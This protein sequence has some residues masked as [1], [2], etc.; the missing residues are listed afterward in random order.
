MAQIVGALQGAGLAAA[1]RAAALWA[2]WLAAERGRFALWLPVFMGA[3]DLAYFSLRGE[4]PGWAGAALLAPSLAAALLARPWPL[5]RAGLAAAAAA[6]FGFAAAQLAAARAPPLLTLPNRATVL[7]GTVDAMEILPEGRRITLRHATLATEA[8]PLPRTLR[9]RLRNDDAAPVET[10]DAV[11]LRAMV[12][13]PSSP[14]Y[15]GAWDVQRDDFFNGIGGYGFALGGVETLTHAPPGGLAQRLHALRAGIAARIAAALPGATG[16]IATTLLTGVTAG[17]PEADRAAFRD[18]G[19]A[20]LLAIAGLHIGIVMGLI[21]GGTRL[22]L[23]CWEWAA[24]RWPI[25]QI[26]ALTALAAGGGYMLLT[27]MHVPIVRSFA[28]ACL[29]TL[30]LLAGRRAVSLRG[31]GLA[32]AVLILMEPEQITGVSFQMSFSAVLALIAG[33]A[34]LR[35]SLSRHYADRRRWRRFLLHVG[36]L[37]LTSLL[38][39]GAS[40]PFA[41]YHFGRVQIYFVVANLVAVP[42]SALWVMPAGLIALAL[43]PFGL[44]RLALV[45]MAWGV[46]G[47]LAIAHTVAAWPNAT[48]PVPHMPVWG[49]AVLALGMA[50]LGLWRSRVRLAG[51]AAIAAAL[52]SPLL[53]R[54]PDLLVSA[55]ARLIAVRTT[56][57]VFGDAQSGAARF[58][59]ESWVQYW[60]HGPMR[61][62]S[63]G[64]RLAPEEIA[65][66]AAACLLRARPAGPAALLLTGP[67][68]AAG[69]DDAVVVVSAEP[70][71][72]RCIGPPLVDRFTVWRNGA[73]AIWLDAGAAELL[74]DR[75]VRGERP[76]VPP[77]PQSR[78]HRA[79]VAGEGSGGVSRVR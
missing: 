69:C 77:P 26:A 58:V 39:G 56:H 22:L 40:A 74:S 36:G 52:A 14:A 50:W 37:A 60:A 33:Y 34:A 2:D 66:D 49:L 21:F 30:A 57:G 5:L 42:L 19:L 1:G 70:A 29:V 27:G 68:E 44:E 79:E 65:C 11:R 10:G 32:G 54:P 16:G 73:Y 41:A 6:S 20:H 46:R 4:P 51:I 25:K 3:G 72:G 53:E 64:P 23:A 24:L 61:P 59:Q 71:R 47:L 76:W 75:G 13:P 31:L 55:D 12:R 8:A 78:R 7:T 18:S 38:A 35:P 43:M 67:G 63:V 28:M 48:L 15:P 17:I 62:L 9:I 45:P